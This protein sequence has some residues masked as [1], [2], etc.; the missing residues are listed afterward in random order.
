MNEATFW[1]D[2]RTRPHEYFSFQV[3]RVLVRRFWPYLR[4]R[5]VLDYGAGL[6]YLV[7]E[8]LDA[9][10]MCAAVEAYDLP[11]PWNKWNFLGT[12]HIDQLA[13]WRESFHTA[14]LVEVIEH[15]HDEELERCL[16][17]V[18][19]LL[20]P[21]GYLIVTTPNQEDIAEG[22]PHVRSWDTLSLCNHLRADGFSV[23]EVG[24]TD[25]GASI[26][27]HYRTKSLPVRLA[28]TIALSLLRRTPHL[29]AVA[30]RS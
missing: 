10:V 3:G 30:Q 8:M 17:N 14:F 22:S 23:R 12:R 24:V 28:R 5:I 19:Y 16:A 18:H 9:G 6:G 21:E 11:H 15:L 25:F 4:G 13:D 27:A 2:Q 26:H 1:A 20:K 29:Y 7:H